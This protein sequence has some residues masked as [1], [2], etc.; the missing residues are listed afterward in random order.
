[1]SLSALLLT[2][3]TMRAHRARWFVYAGGQKLPH[4]ASMRGHWPGW[5][6]ACSCGWESRT[7]GA[8]RTSVSDALLDHRWS[9]QCAAERAA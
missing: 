8:T 1:V 2:P 9:E 7:G 3:E 5:D 6:V 4:A